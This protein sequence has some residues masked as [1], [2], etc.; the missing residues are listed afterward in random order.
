MGQPE[1]EL[2]LCLGAGSLCNSIFLRILQIATKIKK[3][4]NNVLKATITG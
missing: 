2:R 1:P 3:A 4:N